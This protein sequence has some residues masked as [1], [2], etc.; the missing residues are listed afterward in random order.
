MALYE[1]SIGYSWAYNKGTIL[2]NI[3][4]Y[5]GWSK[6]YFDGKLGGYPDYNFI[7]Y[8]YKSDEKMFNCIE[9]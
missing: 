1:D 6:Q 9:K 8:I 3:I 7:K 5:L 2:D 4:S